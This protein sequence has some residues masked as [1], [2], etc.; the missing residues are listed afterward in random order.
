MYVL[1]TVITVI[2][3]EKSRNPF[4]FFMRHQFTISLFFLFCLAQN[5][6]GQCPADVVPQPVDMPLEMADA[7]AQ[8]KELQTLLR[9][10]LPRPCTP[11]SLSPSNSAGALTEKARV[12]LAS[13]DICL[14]DR[15]VVAGQ[16]VQ[17]SAELL[18]IIELNSHLV[19]TI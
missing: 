10:A 3:W 6:K 14:G 2:N 5:E 1:L 7:A 17:L 4:S 12:H 11:L 19:Y 9:E 18:S 8:A 16:K 15:V 13:M